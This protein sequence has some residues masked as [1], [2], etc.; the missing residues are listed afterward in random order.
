MIC[1]KIDCACVLRTH[2]LFFKRELGW[3]ENSFRA[4]SAR[5]EFLPLGPR[6][7]WPKWVDL[8]NIELMF[9]VFLELGLIVWIN[10]QLPE[11]GC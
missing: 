10:P 6:F 3:Y 8:A 5:N 4:Q 11:T 9:R 1:Q 2:S 7:A